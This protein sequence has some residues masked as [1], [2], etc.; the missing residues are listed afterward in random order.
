VAEQ[1]GNLGSLPLT[2]AAERAFVIRTGP[3]AL[4]SGVGVPDQN[5]H[6]RLL[7]RGQP[8]RGESSAQE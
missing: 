7:L 2:T 4:A 1:S 5:E 6:L 3:A 8:T